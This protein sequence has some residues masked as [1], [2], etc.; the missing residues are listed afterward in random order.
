MATT[1]VQK[2]EAISNRNE[3]AIVALSGDE[4]FWIIYQSVRVI[5]SNNNTEGGTRNR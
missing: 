3:E 4:L 2:P 1:K 5:L